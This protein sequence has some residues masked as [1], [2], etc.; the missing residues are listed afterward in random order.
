M[1]VEIEF[2]LANNRVAGRWQCSMA[3]QIEA[4]RG[5]PMSDI[6]RELQATTL[7]VRVDTTLPNSA[8]DNMLSDIE[9][10]LPAGSE[11]IETREV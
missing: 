5:F 2:N 10:F 8:V 11:H 9:D 1:T 7:I 4:N 3:E 6:E